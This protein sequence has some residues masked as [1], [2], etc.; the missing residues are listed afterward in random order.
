MIIDVKYQVGD[1]VKYIH[2][3]YVTEYIKCPCCDGKGFIMGH[4]NMKYNCPSC[5]ISGQI[6]DGHKIREEVREGT[7]SY[8]FAQ[9]DTRLKD[10][11]IIW[12]GTPHDPKIFQSDII[13]RMVSEQEKLAYTD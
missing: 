10:S 3:E 6:K 8:V 5:G 4:D 1:N 13:E 11:I 7:I 9:Y 12:Y 2:K